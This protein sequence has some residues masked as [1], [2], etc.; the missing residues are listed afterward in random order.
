MF[1]GSTPGVPQVV[2]GAPVL[3][4]ALEG[5]SLLLTPAAVSPAAPAVTETFTLYVNAAPVAGY[6]SVSLATLLGY[7]WQAA[8]EWLDAYVEQTLSAHNLAG[9]PVTLTSNTVNVDGLDNLILSIKT[10]AGSFT[11]PVFGGTISA[12][13]LNNQFRFYGDPASTYDIDWGDGTVQNAVTGAQTRTYASSG[14]YRVRTRNWSGVTRRHIPPTASPT[15]TIKVLELQRWGT[16]SWTSCDSM[17]RLAGRMVGTYSDAPNLSA[18]TSCAFMHNNNTA[19]NGSPSASMNAWNM[20]TVTNVNSMFAFCPVFNQSIGGWNV[21]SVATFSSMFQNCLVFNQNIAGWNVASGA[22]FSSMFGGAQGAQAFNQD[23]S[24]WNVA[25][26]TGLGSMFQNA[27]SFDQNISGWNVANATSMFSM[28]SGAT[29]FNRNL[30]GWVLNNA[31]NLGSALNSCG[32]STENYSLTVIGWAN[33]RAATGNP[34]TRSLGAT[35]RTYNNT[36]Y[37]GAPYSD[38]AAARANL[39]AATPGGGGWTITG[40]ALVP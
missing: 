23:I 5:S 25:N 12:A 40:D 31:V 6:T 16:T 33:E 7:V 3:S 39:V 28:F 26:A 27:A 30:G 2:V 11:N 19:F 32:M 1:L 4:P 29:S 35:G 15:D 10:D 22:M 17:F 21:S 37:G 13:T 9:S 24:G 38:A 8:D 14:T 36:S 34:N 18:V 20:S